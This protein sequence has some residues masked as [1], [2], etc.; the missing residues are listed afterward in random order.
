MSSSKKGVNE[1]TSSAIDLIV[2]VLLTIG[3]C[4]LP[5]GMAILCWNFNKFPPQVFG[6]NEDHFRAHVISPIPQSV[7]VLDVEF[8]DIMIHPDVTYYFRFYVDRI[9]LEKIISH[10]KLSAEEGGCS[11]ASYP[12][13]WWDVENLEDVEKYV[14]EEGKYGNLL[15]TLCYD[16]PSKTAYYMFLTY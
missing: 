14:Y 7:E 3:V 8:D 12:P 5:L 15:I 16:A 2:S 13:E 10:R 4:V 6:S 1:L 11:G 9:D